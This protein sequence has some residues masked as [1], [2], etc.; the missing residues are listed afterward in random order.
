[1]IIC[2]YIT[3]FNRFVQLYLTIFVIILE[4][5]R[6]CTILYVFTHD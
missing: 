1:M 6:F 3:D 2:E 5:N 4:L